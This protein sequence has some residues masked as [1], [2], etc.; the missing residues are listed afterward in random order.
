MRDLRNRGLPQGSKAESQQQVEVWRK[1]GVSP[2][3]GRREPVYLRPKAWGLQAEKPEA[4]NV[5]RQ[6]HPIGIWGYVYQ[7]I[8]IMCVALFSLQSILQIWSL[9]NS[10]VQ[11]SLNAAAFYTFRSLSCRLVQGHLRLQHPPAQKEV[12][13][14][15]T[16]V[17]AP[18]WVPQS[19]DQPQGMACEKC[20]FTS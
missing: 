1:R 8:L 2:G 11:K 7:L 16:G 18:L 20:K 19:A 3:V 15:P 9:W 10:Y 4:Q 14:R 13:G 5:A 17:R 12:R 6:G